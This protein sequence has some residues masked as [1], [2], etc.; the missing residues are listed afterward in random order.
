MI[1]REIEGL[2]P[3]EEHNGILF[4]RDDLFMPFE[5]IPLSGGKVRQCLTLFRNQEDMIR[6]KFSGVV[7]TA[8]SV[9]SPQGAIVSAS[10]HIYGFKSI[11]G[12]GGKVDFDKHPALKY[13]EVKYKS[14]LIN[15]CGI[16][17]SN[18]LFKKL[19]DF[20]IE[21]PHFTVRFFTNLEFDKEAILYSNANQ[22][23]NLPDDLDTLVIPCGSAITFSGILIG[24]SKFK[25]KPK[26]VIG[27][28]IA[29]VDRRGDID[30]ILSQNLNMLELQKVKYEFY[31]DKTYPYS[32]KLDLSISE[33]F[34]L[35]NV[36]ESK[37]Y[38]LALKKGFLKGKSLFWIVGNSIP[39]K[40]F[41]EGELN[42]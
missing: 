18:T 19:R 33:G 21:K 24:L 28:Q 7:G 36:Y 41:C 40:K 39:A 26:R 8:T 37:A 10:A 22:C 3:I 11:I 38:E 42:K 32:R 6:E 23:E 13:C 9:D 20:S 16:A 27:I 30:Y 29:G 15:L 34:E 1:V 4:K 12:V 2:T 5:D 31:L 25:K 14:E 35:D 17:Y